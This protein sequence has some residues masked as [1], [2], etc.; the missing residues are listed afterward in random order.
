MGRRRKNEYERTKTKIILI[1]SFRLRNKRSPLNDEKEENDLLLVLLSRKKTDEKRN[2]LFVLS[3][4]RNKKTKITVIYQ[5]QKPN[6]TNKAS[7]SARL[8]NIK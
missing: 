6:G 2:L 8:S 5:R 7:L 4:S 1:S 3:T